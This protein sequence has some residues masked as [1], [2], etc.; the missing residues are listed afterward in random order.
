MECHRFQSLLTH[1]MVRTLEGR[2]SWLGSRWRV[3]LY[4]LGMERPVVC[5]ANLRN[6]LLDMRIPLLPPCV[7]LQRAIPPNPDALRV[8]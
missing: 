8:D 3:E 5:Q 4:A 7:I 2:F 1:S 6:G